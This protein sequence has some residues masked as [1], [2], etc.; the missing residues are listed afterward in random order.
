MS[1]PIDSGVP[2]EASPT[3]LRERENRWKKGMKI[4]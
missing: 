3:G 2:R 1:K 4:E